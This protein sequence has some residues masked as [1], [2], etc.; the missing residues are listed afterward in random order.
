MR[1]AK[2]FWHPSPPYFLPRLGYM[3]R[4]VSWSDSQGRTSM[5]KLSICA[6]AVLEI[7]AS[8]GNQGQ[9]L[10]VIR[11]DQFRS[12][13]EW[14]RVNEEDA[15]LSPFR[16]FDLKGWWS[17]CGESNVFRWSPFFRGWHTISGTYWLDLL[18]RL[19]AFSTRMKKKNDF[20]LFNSNFLLFLLYPRFGIPLNSVFEG[21][22]AAGN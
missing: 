9:L 1:R 19:V 20:F 18:I 21:K 4:H 6:S 7:H 10:D 14:K 16:S 3:C 12:E 13:F 15:L 22:S 11:D 17:R 8:Q 5:F 2:S